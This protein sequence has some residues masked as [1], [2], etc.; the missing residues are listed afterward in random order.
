MLIRKQTKGRPDSPPSISMSCSD[1]LAQW[2]ITGLQGTL[3]S[4]FLEPVYASSIVLGGLL[5]VGGQGQGVHADGIKKKERE[6][7]ERMRKECERALWGRLGDVS[8]R[9]LSF[10]LYLLLLRSPAHSI[11]SPR[12]TVPVPYALHRPRIRLTSLAFPHSREVIEALVR[13]EHPSANWE[14]VEPV[15]CPNCE[16]SCLPSCSDISASIVCSSYLDDLMIRCPEHS[17][18]IRPRHRPRKPRGRTKTGCL[19]QAQK[20]RSSVSVYAVCN[21]S[22]FFAVFLPRLLS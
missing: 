22:R 17:N 15:P 10:L 19:V 21:L 1:K 18:R 12:S 9:T 7:A 16:S 8:S 13:A 2:N 20:R 14:D 11:Y 6:K 3:L 4:A 5:G